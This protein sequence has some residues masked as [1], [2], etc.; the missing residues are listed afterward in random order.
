MGRAKLIVLEHQQQN[1]AAKL[2]VAAIGT[3]HKTA[4]S[5]W[6]ANALVTP[7]LLAGFGRLVQQA[8]EKS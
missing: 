7:I 2:T 3:A 6:L 4:A 1:E 8:E 5:Y